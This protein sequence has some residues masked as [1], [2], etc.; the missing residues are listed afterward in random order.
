MTVAQAPNK[1]SQT[2]AAIQLKANLFTITIMNIQTIDSQLFT[3]ELK[4]LIAKS[5]KFFEN[6]P[7]ILDFSDLGNIADDTILNSFLE[8]VR[9]VGLIPVGIRSEDERMKDQA[10]EL[11]IAVFANNKK[12]ERSPLDE[13]TSAENDSASQQADNQQ[14]DEQ[15][16]NSQQTKI[17]ATNQNP[18]KVIMQPVRSGQQIYAKNAD[19][20]IMASV[21]PG[22]EVLADGHIHIYG[23]LRGRALAGINGN[24]QARIF[25]K[26]LDAELISIAGRYLVNESAANE[27]NDATWQQVYLADEQM[28]IEAI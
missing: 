19:L 3:T 15:H 7:I 25:C 14:A 5:P 27:N 16:M 18:T 6:A 8:S 2:K 23:T 22:A 17:T 11:R 10:I 26:E 24:T 12:V 9:S 1:Q 20:I 4:R 13:N 28:K 21:S